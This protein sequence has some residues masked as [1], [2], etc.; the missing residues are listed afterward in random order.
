MR[1]VELCDCGVRARGR[2]VAD[3]AHVTMSAAVVNL[4]GLGGMSAQNAH[5]HSSD[6][7]TLAQIVGAGDERHA[8]EL[9]EERRIM[10]VAWGPAATPTTF[11]RPLP[12]HHNCFAFL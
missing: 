12:C 1:R 6:F 11:V 7:A 8:N 10:A 9:I 2:H 5:V 3:A 4:L